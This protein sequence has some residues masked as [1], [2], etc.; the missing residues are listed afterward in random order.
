MLILKHFKKQGKCENCLPERKFGN[1]ILLKMEGFLE[2]KN[3]KDENLKNE[4]YLKI[5]IWKVI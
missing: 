5:R 2:P 3:F 4:N 1:K